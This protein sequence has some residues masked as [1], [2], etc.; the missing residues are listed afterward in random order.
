MKSFAQQQNQLEEQKS[1]SLAR[2]KPKIRGANDLA[3]PLSDLQHTIGNRAVLRL[4]QA[5]G[6]NFGSGVPST[7]SPA[8]G[9]IQTKLLINQP[10]DIYEEEAD[11]ISEQVVNMSAP[12]TRRSCACAGDLGGPT[13]QLGKKGERLQTKH[14]GLTNVSQSAA[15]PIVQEVLHSSGQPLDPAC[16]FFM[17][18]RLRRDFSE[19]RVHT[20]SK[21]AESAQAIGAAAYTLGNHLVFGAGTFNPK[22]R[23]G[24]RL[25]AHEL[26]HVRQQSKGSHIVQTQPKKGRVVRVEHQGRWR[27]KPPGAGAFTQE[28]L[29]E[30]YDRHQNAKLESVNLVNG[31][32][33]QEKAYTPEGLWKR[34]YFYAITNVFGNSATEVWV[35][36]D[37]DG[38]VIGIDREMP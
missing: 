27:L 6:E 33:T 30:W 16:R 37:G 25:I 35:N 1:S 19:L 8:A 38:K 20:D 28:E 29:R 22:S 10:G 2:W 21:A 11:R 3:N 26:T 7:C 31:R 17:E 36:N 24:R 34:K 13:E 5:H 14:V 12:Q 32:R 23:E 15:P 4:L 18:P 9:A